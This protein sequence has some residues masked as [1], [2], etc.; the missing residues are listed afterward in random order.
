MRYSAVRGNGILHETKVSFVDF[1]NFIFLIYLT[2]F[3]VIL[4]TDDGSQE[5]GPK[6]MDFV[7]LGSVVE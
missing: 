2:K 7:K 6:R 4:H 3:F 1:V 5:L